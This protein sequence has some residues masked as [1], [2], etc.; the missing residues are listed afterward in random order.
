MSVRFS[1]LLVAIVLAS[2]ALGLYHTLNAYWQNAA[3]SELHARGVRV[4]G[5]AA[6]HLSQH[7]AALQTLAALTSV[8]GYN[9]GAFGARAR[10]LIKKDAAVRAI[11]FFNQDDVHRAHIDAAGP[12]QFGNPIR[13]PMRPTQALLDS[14]EEAMF[15]ADLSR[16]T[17]VSFA[18]ARIGGRGPLGVFIAAAPASRKNRDAG[19]IVEYLAPAPLVLDGLRLALGGG[20]FSL[21]DSRGRTIAGAIAPP[22]G[23]ASGAQSFAIPFGDRILRLVLPAPAARSSNGWLFFFAWLA[24]VLAI[25][26]PMEAVGNLNRRMQSLNEDLEDRVAAR[27]RELEKTLQ[28]SRRLGAVVE[29]VRESVMWIDTDGVVV[30]VNAAL[31]DQ[32]GRSAQD[33]LG[34]RV[35]D[36]PGLGLPQAQ[37]D[38]LSKAVTESGFTYSELDWTRADGTVYVVGVTFSRHSGA[39]GGGSGLI[40]VARDI[41]DRRKLVDQ[42]LAAKH[43]LEHE[44]NARAD[45]IGT[46]S[47]ELRTPV[48][49]L[50]TLSAL[51]GAK[52][53]ARYELGA[54]ERNLVDLLDH[55][56]RRLARLVDDLLEIAKIDAPQTTLVDSVVDVA[57]LVRNELAATQL[58]LKQSGPSIRL[59]LSDRP[60]TIR[61]DENAVRSILNNLVGNARKFTAAHGHIQVAVRCKSDRV[62]LSVADDGIGIPQTDLPHIFER[63][64]RVPQ[65]A[66]GIPGSGLGLA[67]VAR[68]VDLMHGSISVSSEVGRGT[69]VSTEYPMAAVPAPGPKQP[70]HAA[71]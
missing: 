35:V 64:Y 2:L 26:M 41:T 9:P 49:T 17:S 12:P 24:L 38:T 66:N 62:T 47:H 5:D 70:V 1:Q 61:G 55:E 31:C 39:A 10:A 46:A 27:T 7:V 32:I 43:Q 8:E 34:R 67:I 42:L 54:D 16:A 45:F 6:Q 19:T 57:E 60:A 63:F 22:L 69:T 68:L 58:L 21:E 33:I 14:I 51:L 52:F 37:L 15:Y 53:K 18:R 11:D 36:I 30:Y 29:S 48:T 25:C 71:R 23:S 44:I 56:T 40:A 13:T 50:R 28:E 4:A 3:E 59:E 20:A 65:S